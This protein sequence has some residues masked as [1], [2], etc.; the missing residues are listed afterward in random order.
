METQREANACAF[1]S[2]SAVQHETPYISQNDCVAAQID[3]FLLRAMRY[4]GQG[5]GALPAYMP[6][7]VSWLSF[8]SLSVSRFRC[9]CHLK[10][11]VNPIR[12][13]AVV[14]YCIDSRNLVR[15]VVIDG[16]WEM[17]CHCPIESISPG[18]NAGIYGKRVNFREDRVEEIRAK[19]R[20]SLLFVE[21]SPIAKI[22]SCGTENFHPHANSCCSSRFTSSHGRNCA[23]PDSA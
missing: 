7:T 20:A 9:S 21:D 23:S 1:S 16:I 10:M 6:F 4:G 15:N 22:R 5:G 19:G 13:A 2:A 8:L 17:T 12:V 14:Y 3:L 11:A 18:M